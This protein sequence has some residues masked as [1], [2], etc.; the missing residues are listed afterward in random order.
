M[1]LFGM[2]IELYCHRHFS[3]NAAVWPVIPLFRIPK[4]ISIYHQEVS[5]EAAFFWPL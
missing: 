2:I 3:S 1:R 5:S 4:I